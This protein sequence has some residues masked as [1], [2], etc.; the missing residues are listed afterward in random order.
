MIEIGHKETEIQELQMGMHKLAEV[1]IKAIG[2]DDPKTAS[3]TINQM[4][5]LMLTVEDYITF[6]PYLIDNLGQ[7][8]VILQSESFDYYIYRG[9]GYIRHYAKGNHLIITEI[10]RALALVAESIDESKHESLWQ[11][12]CNTLDHTERE[13]V[14]ELDKTFLLQEVHKLAELTGNLDDYKDIERNFYPFA[15][16]NT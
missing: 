6:T 12:A 4:A 8:R 16:E 10:V 3:N 11:F 1:A 14:Y 5:E 9:F 15:N 7:V 2:N 13:V